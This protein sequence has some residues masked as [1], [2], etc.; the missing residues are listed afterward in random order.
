MGTALRSI[1]CTLATIVTIVIVVLFVTGINSSTDSTKVPPSTN[2][3]IV[4]NTRRNEETK[5][6]EY[7]ICD[8]EYIKAIYLGIG[9]SFGY[10]TLDVKIIN[11]T[12]G[13]IT[14]V[15]LESSVD[16]TMIQFVSGVPATMQG[17]K[18]INQVWIIGSE[19]Q[20]NVEFKL[21][22]LDEH[23]SEL[24]VTDVIRIEK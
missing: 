3:S 16:D 15:P 8:N 24:A 14:V 6:N 17:N 1:G 11:K 20:N 19:P 13:E 9:N 21:G 7:V 18:S 23:W 5:S 12:D 22:I 2:E 10:V 4:Q